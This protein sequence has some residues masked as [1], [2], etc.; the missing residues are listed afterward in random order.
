MS[1]EACA[2]IVQQGDPQRFLA[3]M[4][5]P[6][7]ARRVLFPMYA[8]NVEVARAPWVTE[9][10]M[11]AEMR[12]QW[13]RDALEEIATGGPV[14]RHEVTTTLAEVL[15]AEA[16]KE[17]DRLVAVR[18]WDIY[19]DAFE[20]AGHFT[21]Y[22]RDGS[23]LLMWHTARALGAPEAAKVSVINFG[24]AVGCARYLSA[25]SKL[26]AAGRVPLINGTQDAIR[27]LALNMAADAGTYSSLAKSLPKSARPALL[28]GWDAKPVLKQIA[29]EPARVADG[30]V[31]ISPFR[32]K[33]RLLRCSVMR[34]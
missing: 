7:E 25:V 24:A 3:T 4:A 10:P 16:A 27:T 12:L 22:L 28:E 15:D 14:R 11:I 18:R 34:G 32:S 5:A 6:V 9:E 20:D 2:A 29:A 33:V 8:F 19:K 17:L 1:F 23:G 26:E 13:W 30:A 21:E 31:G